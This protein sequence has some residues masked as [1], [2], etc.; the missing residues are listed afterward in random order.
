[1]L[2]STR[3]LLWLFPLL[4]ACSANGGRSPVRPGT[5]AGTRA[6]TSTLADGARPD[7]PF[8]CTPGEGGCLGNT[9][10]VCGD[11]G[12][13]RTSETLCD[14]A[15]D[16]GLRC[17]LCRPDSRRCE[18]NVS[19]RC[20]PNGL[21]WVT[22]RDC[23]EWSSSC[24]GD[25][26]CADACGAAE[27]SNSNVGC[28]YWPTPLANTAELDRSVFDYRVIISN[29]N[30]ADAQIEVTRG[31]SSVTTATVPA[32]GLAEVALPWIDG[33]S[34]AIP[35]NSWSGVVKADGAYRLRSDLPV[36]VAQLNPFEYSNGASFSYT[37]DATLLL[38]SHVLTGDYVGTTYA[39]LS[40]TKGRRGGFGASSTSLKTADYIAVVG[41]TRE[42]TIVEMQLA[43]AVA[44]DASGRW[45]ATSRGGSIMFT[46]QQGEVAHVASGAPP[47]CAPGRPGY[48]SVTDSTPFG[49]DFFDTCQETEYDLTGT[50]I[51]ASQPVE[52]FG[53]HVCAYVPYSAQ[54]CDHL[55]T[56]LAPLQT[57]GT[58]YVST[59]MVDASSPRPNL[60]RVVAAF[61]DTVVGVDP[62]QGG[63]SSV[64][65]GARQWVEFMATG[66][67]HVAGSRA[68]QVSQ[69]MLGQNLT[70][71]AAARGDPAMTIL[72]PQEQWR[73][74]YTF[75]APT[76]YNPGTNGQSYLMITRPVGLDVRLDGTPITSAFSNVAGREVGIVPID[77]GTHRLEAA[78]KFGVIVYGLGSFTSYAYPAG[79][80]LEQIVVLI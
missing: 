68:I 33:Q 73:A 30:D 10:F 18:G 31:G 41:V 36:T 69:L 9:Y 45:P 74:D 79:L 38:P 3:A 59:P 16:P 12:V 70:D 29:P 23:D 7:V 24:G 28:E 67:F 43:G 6:D 13:T 46:L 20:A 26:Y 64:T 14:D 57:W 56:Q 8:S 60:V 55:E 52:V 4:L 65:L 62:P 35:N 53:G 34:F 11:D 1:M 27:A 75:A 49:T 78:D 51:H 80:N 72:V 77:G 32:R 21:A 5:D 71:P 48:N 25:G 39:P 66:P 15:C 40:R 19:M 58:D 76:S 63:V 17:V 50:R 61:N 54:A 37:N 47:D 42:P 2:H 22:G 44:A